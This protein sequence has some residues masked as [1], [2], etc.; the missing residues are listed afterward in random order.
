[1]TRGKGVEMKVLDFGCKV[2]CRRRLVCGHPLLIFFFFSVAVMAGRAKVQALEDALRPA[3]APA[4]KK[5]KADSKTSRAQ[6]IDA[7]RSIA[8]L[9]YVEQ[10]GHVPPAD[11]RVTVLVVATEKKVRGTCLIFICSRAPTRKESKAKER[12]KRG[13]KRRSTL[14]VNIAPRNTDAGQADDGDAA[15]PGAVSA[16]RGH[17][18]RRRDAPQSTHHRLV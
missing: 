3:Q 10:A 12:W 8:G 13:K 4:E 14:I 5:P 9:T 2:P 7:L 18:A 15:A 1:M 6:E 17:G 16:A 11:S